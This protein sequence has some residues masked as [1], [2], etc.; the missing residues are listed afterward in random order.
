[1][2]GQQVPQQGLLQNVRNAM[3]NWQKKLLPG[4]AL[5]A[6]H[7]PAPQQQQ[8]APAPLTQPAAAQPPAPPAAANGTAELRAPRERKVSR[9]MLESQQSAEWQPHELERQGRGAAKGAASA[10]RSTATPSPA[11][12]AP[13]ATQPELSAEEQRQVGL[14]RMPCCADRA[15]YSPFG[16]E[17]SRST[18][19]TLSSSPPQPQTSHSSFS[20]L[21]FPSTAP[22]VVD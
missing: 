8:G 6:T 3:H 18:L 16:V 21:R 4:S 2:H 17:R 1:M 22:V 14:L 9:K 20:E 7:A 11:P 12:D 10:A 13:A 5:A 19:R 15:C